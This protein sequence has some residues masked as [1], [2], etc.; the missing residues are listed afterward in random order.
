MHRVLKQALA[1]AVRWR[2]LA[3]NPCDDLEKKDRPKIEKKAVATIDAAAT[4]QAIEAAR[5]SSRQHASM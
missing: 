2:I 1:Q 5:A 3:R 4:M